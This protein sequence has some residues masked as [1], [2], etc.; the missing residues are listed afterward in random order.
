MVVKLGEKMVFG[1]VAALAAVL[2]NAG[3]AEAGLQLDGPFTGNSFWWGIGDNNVGVV[4]LIAVRAVNSNSYFET[5]K[6]VVSI[7]SAP[8][9]TMHLGWTRIVDTPQM[10][11]AE[12]PVGVDTTLMFNQNSNNLLWGAAFWADPNNNL[13]VQWDIAFFHKGENAA[14]ESARVEANKDTGQFIGFDIWTPNRQDITGI[15][16][17]GTAGLAMFGLCGLIGIGFVRRLLV[18]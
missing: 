1:A 10:A 5:G 14:F 16:L 8:Q 6:F 17:P 2:G 18:A 12:N 4:D 3:A 7:G 13:T 15:P 11:A 9:E